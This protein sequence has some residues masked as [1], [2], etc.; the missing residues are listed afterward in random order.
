MTSISMLTEAV[1]ARKTCLM[2]G[3]AFLMEISS[4]VAKE[5]GTVWLLQRSWRRGETEK[6]MAPRRE[7]CRGLRAPGLH[8]ASCDGGV[9]IWTGVADGRDA[10]ACGEGTWRR[11]VLE[12]SLLSFLLHPAGTRSLP[13][14][15]SQGGE[16][17]R[18]LLVSFYAACDDDAWELSEQRLLPPSLHPAQQHP[19]QLP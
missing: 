1:S 3:Q 17:R 6:M 19:C 14:R 11:V 7:L 15:R 9:P 10:L 5:M 8:P 4:L 13:W 18:A 16:D 12:P 2:G